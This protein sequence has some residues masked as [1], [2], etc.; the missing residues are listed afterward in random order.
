MTEKTYFINLGNAGLG[1]VEKNIFEPCPTLCGKAVIER[2]LI[3]EY[4]LLLALTPF[5]HAGV[6][7][8]PATVCIVGKEN[9]QL[10]AETIT[11]VLEEEKQNG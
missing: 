11:K 7:F 1:R 5:S 4:K 8:P 9:L 10:I 3:E 2:P 6:I